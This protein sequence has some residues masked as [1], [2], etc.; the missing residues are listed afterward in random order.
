MAGNSNQGG[1]VTRQ[2]HPHGNEFDTVPAVEGAARRAT[3]LVGVAVV[4]A[5]GFCACGTA[6]A[7]APEAATSV[8]ASPGVLPGVTY[9]GGGGSNQSPA[10]PIPGCDSPYQDDLVAVAPSPLPAAEY[11]ELDHGLL[12]SYGYGPGPVYLSGQLVWYESGDE[13]AI[14]VDRSVRVPVTV[15]F[16]GPTGSSATFEGEQTVTIAPTAN[17]WAFAEG[18]LRAC[19]NSVSERLERLG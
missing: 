17:G 13:T 4:A 8:P 9:G 6:G 2:R 5:I 15:S 12:F 11:T 19:A 16:T 7:A 10:T 14:M 1:W 18:R 3:A